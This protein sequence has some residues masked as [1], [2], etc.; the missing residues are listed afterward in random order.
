MGQGKAGPAW[1]ADPIHVTLEVV[2][3]PCSALLACVLI[4]VNPPLAMQESLAWLL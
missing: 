1:P 2:P 4:L 3:I